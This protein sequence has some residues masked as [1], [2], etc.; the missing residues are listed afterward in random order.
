[1]FLQELR[2]ALKAAR[3]P[4]AERYMLHCMR[5]GAAQ[6]IIKH[7]GTLADVLRACG[8]KSASFR[9]YLEMGGVEAMASF[10]MLHA[11]D[12]NQQELLL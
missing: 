1:M 3:V 8:W 5:R 9:L 6:A 2:Q 11:P 4:N 12:A 10:H 7:G